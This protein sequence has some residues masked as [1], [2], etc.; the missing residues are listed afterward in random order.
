MRDFAAEVTPLILTRDE[1]PN[2][3]RTLAQLAWAREVVVIDSISHDATVEIAKSFPN[4]RVVQRPLDDL[5]SQWTFG[6]QQV[7]TPWVLT[8]DA[9]YFVPDAFT[10]ELRSLDPAAEVAAYEARFVYAVNGRRL[11]ASLY[12]P[13][14][15]LL[16]LGRATF[17]M[18][19]HA[20]QV[21]VDGATVKLR[22]PLVHDDRKSFV[23][24]IARQRKYMRDE[25]AKIRRGENLNA[26]AR[27]RKLRVVA[28]LVIVPYV[29][30]V[31]GVLLDGLPGLRYT[32]ERF[33]A[34]VMLSWE[35]T[36]GVRKKALPAD[37]DERR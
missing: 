12:P 33:V 2:I 11:R 9:D 34:E 30:L 37:V 15:V 29:L 36:F 22:E 35:L 4:V 26:P 27:V 14:P 21:R 32:L 20:Q 23:R 6:L 16:R 8:L 3:A 28:P 18:H 24:F 19:G 10:S 25:A 7:K 17:A 5:A 31:K 1:E 13:R